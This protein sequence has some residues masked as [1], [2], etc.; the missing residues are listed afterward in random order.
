MVV[1]NVQIY[2]IYLIDSVILNVQW[3][4][5]KLNIHLLY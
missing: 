1:Y 5:L 3:D 4:I 2:I